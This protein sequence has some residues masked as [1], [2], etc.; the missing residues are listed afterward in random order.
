MIYIKHE[1]TVHHRLAWMVVLTASLFF[2]YEFIQLNLFNAIDVSLMR[3]F[4]INA[5]QLGQLASMYFYANALFL[6]PAG[7]LLDRFST[8]K[9]LLVAVLLC[10]VGTYIFAMAP[11]YFVAAVGRFL[12]G[13]GAAF[14]F[15]SCIRLA[16]RWFPPERMAFV[17][18]VVVVMAMLGGLVAQ[19]PFALL[20]QALGWRHAVMINATLGIFIFIAILLIVQDRPPDAQEEAKKDQQQL[21]SLGL[22][23]CI[24]LAAL[25]PQNWLGGIYT[26]LMNL[27]VFLLGAL[28]GIHYLQEVH[29]LSHIQASYATTIFFIG[30]IAGSPTFGWFSDHLGRRVLPMVIGA[31]LSLIVIFFL[32]CMPNL[33]LGAIIFLFFLIGFVTSSQVLT[34]PTVAELNPIYLTSTAVSIDSICIMM[35]GFIFQ[36]FFGW[37]MDQA[38][39][40]TVVN[41]VIHY[42]IKDFDRAMWIMPIAFMIALIVTFFIRETYCK[43]QA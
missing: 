1:K 36:P 20:A 28:W 14:C 21:K 12:V 8:K 24:K 10:T 33:S 29:H 42:T 6:F 4:N 13:I 27:P 5:A 15:L 18:G 9:I 39:H 23:R 37:V 19:T 31:V 35:S 32:M 17:T 38:S 30:V 16:S 11:H 41:G 26:S 7:N 40:H 43:S 25:N 2:F 3:D 22:W 34:Y